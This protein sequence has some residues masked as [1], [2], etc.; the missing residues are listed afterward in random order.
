[1]ILQIIRLQAGVVHVKQ[2][3][4]SWSGWRTILETLICISQW[5]KLTASTPWKDTEENADLATSSTQ[6]VFYFWFFFRFVFHKK[7][8]KEVGE[9]KERK[10]KRRKKKKKENKRESRNK[11]RK[12]KENRKKKE[13]SKKVKRVRKKK[14]PWL[15]VHAWAT[16]YKPKG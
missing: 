10:R 1:M 15:S 2:C 13:K 4:A 14:T 3:I 9:K 8:L 12:K 16:R 11:K 7:R 6:V 5:Q